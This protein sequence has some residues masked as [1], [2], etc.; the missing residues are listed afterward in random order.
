MDRLD[1]R[2]AGR[3]QGVYFRAHAR[4]QA[5]ALGLSGIV[6]NCAD[7][8][9]ETIAEGTRDALEQYAAWLHHGPSAAQVTRV[10][11]NWSHARGEFTQFEVAPDAS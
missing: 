8:C 5:I 6:R 1:A 10:T 2:I 4:K 9:V 11:V 3:V 7:G